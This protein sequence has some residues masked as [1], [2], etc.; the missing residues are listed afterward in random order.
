MKIKLGELRALVRE[1]IKPTAS[2]TDLDGN[3]DAQELYDL[4]Q[5][6]WGAGGV[7]A[8]ATEDRR[9]AEL[10]EKFP[11]LVSK[12][13]RNLMK[14]ALGGGYIYRGVSVPKALAREAMET[15]L[16]SRGQL[17]SW[18][19]SEDIA[20]GFAGGFGG[21]VGLLLKADYDLASDNMV[22]CFRTYLSA[23]GDDGGDNL[24]EEEFLLRDF[25]VPPDMIEKA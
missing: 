19:V 7:G 21:N 5:N 10:A 6:R 15:G 9:I 1:A 3:P 23:F 8:D 16:P 17:S 14:V 11:D 25:L 22:C 2:W 20:R 12:S 24:D 18:S 13:N 4:I